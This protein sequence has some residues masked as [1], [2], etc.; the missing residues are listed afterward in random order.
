MSI[1]I[2]I[3]I[4]I[5]IFNEEESI[6]LLIDEVLK[7][8]R[9]TQEKFEIILVNDGSKDKSAEVLSHLSSSIP[10]VIAVLLRK[11]YG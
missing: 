4:V 2:D 3:S 11:N 7:V 8:M 1:L 10:E 9:V 5:P 6:P